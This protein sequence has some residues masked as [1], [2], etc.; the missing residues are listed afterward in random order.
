VSKKV[1]TVLVLLV[2]SVLCLTIFPQMVSYGVGRAL[3]YVHIAFSF[4]LLFAIYSV[5]SK[6]ET[7]KKEHQ[8]LAQVN[9][10][11]KN[12]IYRLRQSLN[13]SSRTLGTILTQEGQA[14]L[15]FTKDGK[16]S[17]T[18]SRSC[19]SLLE[20]EP[21]NMH[22]AD[23]LRVPDNERE[24]FNNWINILFEQLIDFEEAIPLGPAEFFGTR[25][26]S[27]SIKYE[28]IKNDVD[29]LLSVLVV[30]QDVTDFEQISRQAVEKAEESEVIARL[31]KQKESF[32]YFNQEFNDGIKRFSNLVRESE[33]T[34]QHVKE[35]LRFLHGVKGGFFQIGL[36][37]L[38]MQI[39]DREDVWGEI[40]KKPERYKD[41]L[42][43]DISFLRDGWF[44]F[45]SKYSKIVGYSLE[46]TERT[47]EFSLS[48]AF[49][50]YAKL[51]IMV[52]PE[53]IN[54]SFKE[55]L[56]K[57]I[58][59]YF[60]Q[61]QDLVQ[62][63][64]KS[65]NKEL[66]PMKIVGGDVKVIPEAYKDLFVSMGHLFRNSIDHGIETPERRKELHKDSSG[67]I[68]LRFSKIDNGK[69][70]S[71]LLI[72]VVDDGKGINPEKLRESL[73]KKGD[74]EAESLKDEE[75]IQK[76]FEDGISTKSDKKNLL[77]GRGVGVSAVKAAVESMGGTIVVSSEINQGCHFKIQVPFIE[78]NM[79]NLPRLQSLA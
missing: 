76:I 32:M 9:E 70:Q 42:I 21:G 71:E 2:I 30:A 26:R 63:I 46:D 59:K 77:S 60:E 57:S 24:D 51:S 10:K 41:Q 31:I 43:N 22:I 65:L 17:L 23:V 29:E 68:E 5:L 19:L 6:L 55:K 48:E 47:V 58:G 39:H 27:I 74:K 53:K 13:D 78:L 3:Q 40:M 62:E 15:T 14:Y 52:V 33:V 12:E 18:Y 7:E 56:M 49:D 54:K 61:Y 79:Q 72:E 45:I 1:I 44:K 73:M 37:S 75:V 8:L 35:Y 66:H 25:G 20:C 36:A 28:P 11:K 34:N 16:V 38:G 50:L 64:A 4:V 69:K 67:S